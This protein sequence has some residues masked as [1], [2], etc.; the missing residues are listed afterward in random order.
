MADIL[1][2]KKKGFFKKSTGALLKLNKCEIH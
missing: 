2:E 1:I